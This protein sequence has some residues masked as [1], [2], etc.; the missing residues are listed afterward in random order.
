MERLDTAVDLLGDTLS[1][2]E[3]TV[4]D[5]KKETQGIDAFNETLKTKVLFDVLPE[6]LVLQRPLKI[7]KMVKPMIE[8]DGK[9]LDDL[10]NKYKTK[11][12]ILQQQ[13]KLLELKLE[14]LTR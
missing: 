4:S 2:L 3:N 9:A 8:K 14:T 6:R 1:T 5:L 7:R 10:L 12:Q 13:S 11:R